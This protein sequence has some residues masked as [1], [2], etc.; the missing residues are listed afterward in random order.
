MD[1]KV[2]G[3]IPPFAS[4]RIQ[5]RNRALI[6]DAALA[7][8]AAH[9][10]RG[11]TIDRIAAEAGM[12]KPNVLYYFRRKQDIYEAVLETTLDAWLAP[13]EALDP[14][15]EP[16][17]ELRRYISAKLAMSAERPEASRLFM[18]EVLTGAPV[19]G[20]FLQT[21]LRA[22]VDSKAAVIRGWIAA[23]RLAPVDPVHLVFAIWATTQ[24]YA[25][26]DAQIRALLGSSE[27]DDVGFRDEAAK[28]VLTI[29]LDGVR[30]RG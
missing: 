27:V 8:F 9:G 20:P 11:A 26:F 30:P 3:G 1:A 5:G 29:I 2:G 23:G 15:G 21:R 28:A 25:D 14:T 6:L 17:E 4:T 19:I 13:L 16:V 22:L 24:H 10:F 18:G 7:V 12:S